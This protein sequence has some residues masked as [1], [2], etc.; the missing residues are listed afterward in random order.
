VVGFFEKAKRL[1]RLKEG[2]GWRWLKFGWKATNFLFWT[3]EMNSGEWKN[4]MGLYRAPWN[5]P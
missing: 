1:G 2:L 4:W 3:V 5:C